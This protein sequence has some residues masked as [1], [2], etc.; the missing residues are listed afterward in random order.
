MRI[1]KILALILVL[2]GLIALAVYVARHTQRAVRTLAI[3]VLR[4]IPRA[5]LVLEVQREIA[6]ATMDD[7]NFVFGP[8][9]GH[10]TASRK[11]YLGVDMEKVGPGDIEVNGRQV[12]VRLPD[13]SALDSSLD[14]GSVRLFAK[15]S[16]FMLLRDLASGRSIERELLDLLSTTTPEYTTE[17]LRAQ[18]QS[19]VDRLNRGAGELFKAKRLSVTFK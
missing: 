15:R 2:G 11:T 3:E 6:V 8:R 1:L 4:S 14:Y 5:F 12:Q 17:D 19:F 18:R 7:G 9:V 16:G 13:P 10:A